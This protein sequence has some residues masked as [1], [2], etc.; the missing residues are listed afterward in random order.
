MTN[1]GHESTI[2]KVYWIYQLEQ[3]GWC[4]ISLKKR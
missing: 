3:L 4:G 2:I 1:A